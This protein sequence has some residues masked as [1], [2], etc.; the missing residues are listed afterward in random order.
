MY[1]YVRYVINNTVEMATSISVA[2]VVQTHME[3]LYLNINYIED[4]VY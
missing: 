4:K 3:N 1:M 2:Y